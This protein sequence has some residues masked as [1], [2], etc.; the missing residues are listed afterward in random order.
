M[1]CYF[2]KRILITISLIFAVLIFACVY[3]AYVLI[4]PC[5]HKIEN[6][7]LED[8]IKLDNLMQKRLIDALQ[9]KTITFDEKSQN[10]TAIEIFGKFIRS[11]MD[12][13]KTFAT[14]NKFI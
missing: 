6:I 10:N 2:L 12:L 13:N 3:R 5:N 11:G 7:K 1:A 9:I 8:V 4:K 14:F